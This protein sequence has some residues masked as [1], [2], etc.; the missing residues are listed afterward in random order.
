M[1]RKA[2]TDTLVQV[3]TRLCV[4]TRRPGSDAADLRRLINAISSRKSFTSM[5]LGSPF[6]ITALELPQFSHAANLPQMM[7]GEAM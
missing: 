2:Q 5:I 6:P 4:R 3:Q 7:G 1:P